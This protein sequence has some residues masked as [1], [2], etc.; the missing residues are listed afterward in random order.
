MMTARWWKRNQDSLVCQN[1][2]ASE[3]GHGSFE[4]WQNYGDPQKF[5]KVLKTGSCSYFT[6]FVD[7][8]FA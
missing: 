4:D 1:L 6:L 8:F 3:A 7:R 5:G 2:E